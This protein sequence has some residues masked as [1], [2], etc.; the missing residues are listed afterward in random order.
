MESVAV[1]QGAP[2]LRLDKHFLIAPALRHL[3]ASF[4]GEAVEPWALWLVAS[5]GTAGWMRYLE[6]ALGEHL[7]DRYRARAI[8][9]AA[10]GEMFRRRGLAL[11]APLK[12]ALEGRS[13]A[14]VRAFFEA[15]YPGPIGA[16]IRWSLDGIAR[17]SPGIAASARAWRLAGKVDAKTRWLEVSHH[18]GE[19]TIVLTELLPKENVPRAIGWL[20]DTSHAFG[21]EVAELAASLFGMPPTMESAIETLR[22]GEFL[23]RVNPEHTSGVGD[24]Q[25]PGFI[26][27]SACLWY[28]RPGWKQV[29]CGVLG[30]FQAGISEVFG[31]TYSL[32]QTIPKHGGDTCRISM[33]PIQLR[34]GAERTKTPVRSA[35]APAWEPPK[36]INSRKRHT[37]ALDGLVRGKDPVAGYYGPESAMWEGIRH[38]VILLGGGRAALMQLAHPAVAHAIRD[39]SVVH[40]DM[41]GR[42]IRTMMSAY[43]IIFGSA[44]EVRAVSER[45]YGIHAAISGQLDDVPGQEIR[46]Y[47]ALDPEAVFWVGATLFDTA[48]MVYE[49]MVRPLDTP[50]RD[51]LVREASTFWVAFGLAPEA[52]PTNWADLHGYVER[53]IEQLAPLVGDTAR[54]QAARLFKPQAPFVQPI[55]DQLRLITAE[56]LPASLQRALRM[57]LNPQER[58]LAR[59]WIFAAERLVPWLPDQIRYV[60]A[61]H[62][63][64][65]RL[66][67][68][69]RS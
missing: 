51:R 57:E 31:Q 12:E 59:S 13:P 26:E 4:N 16:S 49:R 42:F 69:R 21:K 24:E 66:R 22:M 36:K 43:T 23:F 68:A 35:D 61:Y 67:A 3:R 58:L 37:E 47:H 55:F 29:H 20:G 33:S 54:D 1:T 65:R 5:E 15:L 50:D 46:R 6:S 63:A 9:T 44:D 14:D 18:L 11:A 32:T 19:L 48:M 28:E 25:K 62:T 8:M 52:C 17:E 10:C 60:P 56:M 39:H 41:L 30:R 7:D 40:E 53:R 38:S 2:Q 34:V 64:Q 45:V 27:G